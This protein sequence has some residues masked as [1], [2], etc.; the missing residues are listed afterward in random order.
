[1]TLYPADVLQRALDFIARTQHR[2]P[3][4]ALTSHHYGLDDVD[5]AFAD[6]D[7]FTGDAERAVTRAAVRPAGA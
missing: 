5:R 3:F 1:M 6:G 7:V 2:Y 4:A